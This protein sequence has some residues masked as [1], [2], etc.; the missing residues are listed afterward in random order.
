MKKIYI[1]FIL[2]IG[3]N[4]SAEV[5]LT[6]GQFY[7]TNEVKLNSFLSMN[8][9]LNTNSNFSGLVGKST[10][11]ELDQRYNSTNKS[12]VYCTRVLKQKLLTS[13]KNKISYKA[14]S[15]V[16]TFNTTGELVQICNK[17]KCW[18]I[19]A[20]NE[21]IKLKRNGKIETV[22][23]KKSNK[24]VQIKS[25]NQNLAKFVYRG[26]QIKSFTSYKP[27][28]V[29]NYK[30]KNNKLVKIYSDKTFLRLSYSGNMI[31]SIKN[32]KGCGETYN[33]KKIKSSKNLNTFKVSLFNICE[34]KNRFYL[35]GYD[36][37][38]K[39]RQLENKQEYEK[40]KF[41][42]DQNL[43][44]KTLKD[45]T[46]ILYRDNKI[47][48]LIS[49][50]DGKATLFYS[51]NKISKIYYEKT[52]KRVNL[53]YSNNKIIN[54]KNSSGFQASFLYNKKIPAKIK[55][56]SGKQIQFNYSKKRLESLDLKS[57][58]KTYV[59]KLKKNKSLISALSVARFYKTLD[60]NIG[61]TTEYV[62]E[63]KELF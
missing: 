50:R 47:K 38:F 43:A 55:L 26:D 1:L 19:E 23:Y 11:S 35:I 15:K 17:A 32:N 62:P 31:K 30:Y 59:F 48:S 6:T 42:R 24:V 56:N 13:E 10:C 36:S 41:D 44:K 25:K 53:T 40:F 8:F 27:I 7:L 46:R 2:L 57:K 22:L 21:Q 9:T 14:D 20:T 4:V 63:L 54:L 51:N 49:P 5:N 3:A 37:K 39:V 12:I 45:S 60:A 28:T 52:K 16:Y 18:S 34:K 29:Y 58:N 33:Y 61:Y